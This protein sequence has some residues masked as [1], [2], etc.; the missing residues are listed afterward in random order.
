[1]FEEEQNIENQVKNGPEKLLGTEAKEGVWERK[2]E[3]VQCSFWI[4]IRK[5]QQQMI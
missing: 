1:M 3:T 4:S 2:R 5:A